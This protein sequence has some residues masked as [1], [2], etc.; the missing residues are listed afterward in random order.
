MGKGTLIPHGKR[1][2][3]QV[4]DFGDEQPPPEVCKWLHTGGKSPNAF[5]H[6]L[7]TL[8]GSSPGPQRGLRGAV[9]GAVRTKIK[10]KLQESMARSRGRPHGCRVTLIPLS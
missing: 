1:S 10:S 5:L 4:W 8:R 2:Q 9:G 3:G 7:P 6:W